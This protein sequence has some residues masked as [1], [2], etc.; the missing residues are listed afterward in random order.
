MWLALDYIYNFIH[1]H[2]LMI[3]YSSCGNDYACI[4]TINVKMEIHAILVYQQQS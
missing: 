4:Y 2:L 1:D 3:H